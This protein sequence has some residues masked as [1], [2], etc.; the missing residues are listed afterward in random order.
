[1]NFITVM[2]GSLSNIS[3]VE[4]NYYIRTEFIRKLHEA[5][6]NEKSKPPAFPK[7]PHK[8]PATIPSETSVITLEEDVQGVNAAKLIASGI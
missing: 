4:V 3:R 8:G 6:I 5:V 7:P 1:M 2:R